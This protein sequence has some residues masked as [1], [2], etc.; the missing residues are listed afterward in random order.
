MYRTGKRMHVNVT[1][2][3]QNLPLY[4]KRAQSG[5]EVVI[6]NR[7]KVIAKLVPG[8]RHLIQEAAMQ[9]LQSIRGQVLVYDVVSSGN[10]AGLVTENWTGDATHL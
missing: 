10:D 2:L 8:H 6:A 5:E 3:R 4:L 9:T 7:G 1:E